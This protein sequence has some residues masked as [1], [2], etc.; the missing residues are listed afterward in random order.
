[1]S[2]PWP[3]RTPDDA[4]VRSNFWVRVAMDFGKPN[5]CWHWLGKTRGGYGRVRING[6]YVQ[7]HRYAWESWNGQMSDDKEAAHTCDNRSCCNPNHIFPATPLEN[8]RDCIIKGRARKRD[9]S[10]RIYYI[11]SKDRPYVAAL[12]DSAGP[13]TGSGNQ[14]IHVLH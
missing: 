6:R 4:E 1:M 7:A 9:R 8:T 3:R 10:G 11:T 5:D 2:N 14:R 12:S 13:Y